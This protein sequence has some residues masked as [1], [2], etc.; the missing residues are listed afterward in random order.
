M[1]DVDCDVLICG[2]GPV[3]PLLALLLGD[4]GVRTIAIERVEGPDVGSCQ[5]GRRREV[6]PLG[7]VGEIFAPSEEG[8]AARLMPGL[9]PIWCMPTPNWPS[10]VAV[11]P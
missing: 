10:A 4:R 1:D 11:R 5:I 7:L 3:G 8:D 9:P 6:R 2:L